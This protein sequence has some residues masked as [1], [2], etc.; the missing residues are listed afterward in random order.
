[1]WS[2]ASS[3]EAAATILFSLALLHTF[4]AS[5]LG[6][7]S[8][9]FPKD[10]VRERTLH[11]LSEVEVVFGLW[12][13]VYILFRIILEGAHP[14]LASMEETRFSEAIFVFVIM[15]VASTKPIIFIVEKIITALAFGGAF[16]KGFAREA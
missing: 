9:R 7:L 10:S 5:F 4:A 13:T 15:I 8:K 2:K 3:Q 1:M 6:S 14:V 11:L 12:A 16:G